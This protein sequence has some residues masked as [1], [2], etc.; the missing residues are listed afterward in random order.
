[1]GCRSKWQCSMAMERQISMKQYRVLK[2]N[3][4]LR[5]VEGEIVY[6]CTKH[7]WG[8]VREETEIQGK[9]CIAVTKEKDGSYPFFVVPIE[10]LSLITPHAPAPWIIVDDEHKNFVYGLNKDGTNRFSFLVQRGYVKQGAN[11]A[12][13]QKTSPEEIQAITKLAASAPYLLEAL[14]LIMSIFSKCSLPAQGGAEEFSFIYSKQFQIAY[15][16]INMAKNIKKHE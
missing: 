12:E 10:N 3:T 15:D 9:Q 13:W 8:L 16:A 5:L 4:H 6:E 1:M 11:K 7:D 2:T 14:E